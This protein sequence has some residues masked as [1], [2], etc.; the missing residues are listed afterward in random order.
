MHKKRQR[1]YIDAVAILFLCLL[2]AFRSDEVGTDTRGYIQPM[3]QGAISS[4]NINDFFQYSWTFTYS[5][6][7]V[8][9]YE[10]GYTLV[11]YLTSVIFKSI[12]V[13]QFVLELLIVLP[14]YIALRKKDD[15]S[16]WFGMLVFMLQ[17]FNGSM[18]LNRQSI[19]MAFLFCALTFWMGNKKKTC[20]VLLGIGTLFHITTLIGIIIVLIYEYVGREKK[21]R[22]LLSNK[23]FNINYIN[24]LIAILAG[25]ILLLGAGLLSILMEHTGLA[26]YVY[27]IT[28]D[29]HFMPNQVLYVLPPL[30]I[31][32]LSFK[33]FN[34][35]QSEWTFYIVMIIYVII[36]GQFT[37]ASAF[38]GRIGLY[39]KMFAIFAY[40][41][42][43]KYSKYKTLS[44][45]LMISYLIF[46]WGF[47][48]VYMGM[49]ATVPYVTLN[50]IA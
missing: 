42:A 46:Y 48:Y 41:L 4:E 34:N 7:S 13:T 20:V 25:I 37:S 21:G 1:I 11:V 32:I 5:R 9:D 24:M 30:V 17:F 23:S 16:I 18:N 39:F 26:K 6:K 8:I 27:Y 12:V 35:R 50:Q 44:S 3:I 47:Y 45:F 43:C 10:I 36:A 2:A 38:S 49:D 19:G 22:V 14:V 40:P 31:L 15:V 33:N 29:I 28:G